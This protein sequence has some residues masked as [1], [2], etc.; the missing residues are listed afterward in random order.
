MFKIIPMML[1]T[2][3]VTSNA[4]NTMSIYTH[5]DIF[6]LHLKFI[7]NLVKSAT[8]KTASGVTNKP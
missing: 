8:V 7:V 5:G 1:I 4:P 6:N 2:K 3:T